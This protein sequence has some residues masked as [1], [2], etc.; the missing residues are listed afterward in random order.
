MKTFSIIVSSF[1]LLTMSAYP[2]QTEDL[3]D[4]EKMSVYSSLAVATYS[5]DFWI[6][7]FQ[8]LEE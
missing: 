2:K 7:H 1:I 4:D 6:N 3:S 8:T 5:T